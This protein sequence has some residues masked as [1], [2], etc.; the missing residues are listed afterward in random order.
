MRVHTEYNFPEGQTVSLRLHLDRPMDIDVKRV[1]E[2][3]LL[4][5]MNVYGLQFE[6]PTE[7]QLEHIRE[8]LENYMPGNRRKSFRLE[9][10]LVVEMQDGKTCKR[11]GVFTLDLS[12]SGMRINHE[13]PLPEGRELDL[14]ILLNPQLPPIDVKAEV[15]WQKENAFGHHLIGLRFLDTSPEAIER[16]EETI[17][18]ASEAL[19]RDDQETLS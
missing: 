5:G 7:P 14:R 3:P 16:I 4:G 19:N 10:I 6:S 2:K 13:T 8:F 17:Q 12:T 11:F 18:Q 1:W 9:R 15:S